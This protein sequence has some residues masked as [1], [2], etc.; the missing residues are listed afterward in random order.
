MRDS[1]QPRP[2]RASLSTNV[3]RTGELTAR[4][5]RGE[6]RFL[7]SSLLPHRVFREKTLR[8]AKSR[9]NTATSPQ[10]LEVDP[11]LSMLGVGKYLWAQEPG[12]AF[13]D[14]LRSEDP[15]P[16]PNS[17]K[18]YPFKEQDPAT[19]W[20]RIRD[21]Q[22]QVFRTARKLPFTYQVEG[23][24]IWFFREG[25]RINRKVSRIQVEEAISR[26]PLTRTTQIKDLIDYP[27]VFALLTDARIRGGAW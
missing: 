26:C 19:V 3:I 15:P 24:G 9:P 23:A 11:V 17:A 4:S 14:R 2:A 10:D 7:I 25:R 6:R 12:D 22:G 8:M 21:H 16:S 20:Q 5:S 1:G 18:L 13:V 27:Y